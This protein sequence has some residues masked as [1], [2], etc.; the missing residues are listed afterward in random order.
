MFSE[1]VGNVY[2]HSRTQ[3]DGYA[4]LQVYKN[5]NSARIAVSDSGDGLLNTLRPSLPT[6]YPRLVA[7]GTQNF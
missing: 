2:E 6:H 4:V 3:L 5:G 1:L 7:W